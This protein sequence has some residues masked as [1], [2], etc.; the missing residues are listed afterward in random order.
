MDKNKLCTM[1]TE[2]PDPEEQRYLIFPVLHLD[3]VK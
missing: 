2:T 1:H 3:S